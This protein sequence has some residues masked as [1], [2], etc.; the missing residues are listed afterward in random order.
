MAKTPQTPDI[1]VRLIAGAHTW[2]EGDAIKQLHAQA[3]RPGMRAAVGFPDM[4]P[5][6]GSPSG[7]VFLSDLIYPSIVG[8]DIGCGMALWETDYPVRKIKIDKIKARLDGLDQPWDGDTAAFLAQHNVRP[9][10]YDASLGT[11]GH[12]N[13]FIELQQIVKIHDEASAAE[14]KLNPDTMKIVVHSGSRGFG[15]AIF[16]EYAA[17]HD[18]TGL[19]ADSDEGQAYLAA[20]NHAFR[21]AR[22]NRVLCVR[23][24]LEALNCTGNSVLDITHNAVLPFAY[25]SCACWLHRKGA[26]PADCGPVIIPGSRDDLTFIV[27][28]IAPTD[29]LASLAHG[30][31]RK[32]ARRE[33]HGK[34]ER[35]YPNKEKL[36]RNQ[37]GGEV[38]CGDAPLLWQEAKECYKDVST[39]I[40]DL[41][42]AGLIAC[43]A[44][45]RPLVTFKSS[46]ELREGYKRDRRTR[47]QERSKARAE[48]RR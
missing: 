27:Q 47:Q 12:S 16:M 1:D 48:K 45:L 8:T 9:T 18:A 31:G 35:L 36:K 40:H 24:V 6:K 4:Q 37:W 26:A 14:L 3:A 17:R 21:L 46:E 33:A 19:S 32:I 43:I 10:A 29:A 30:A 44:S 25:A 2:I 13:H 20:H 5:G 39:V 42:A 34:L 22:A 11:P 23:R 28:P 41:E 15:E 38:I 7:A